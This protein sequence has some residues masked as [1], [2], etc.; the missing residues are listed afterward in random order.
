MDRA[1]A[2]ETEL[3]EHMSRLLRDGEEVLWT[4]KP[5]KKAFYVTSIVGGLFVMGFLGMFFLMPFVGFITILLAGFAGS[6]EAAVGIASGV[7]LLVALGVVGL[8]YLTTRWQYKNT[9]FG[10]TQDR[11]I[12]TSGIIGRDASTL[13]L[14]DVRDV[15]VNVGLLDKLFDT[16]TIELQVAGGQNSGCRFTRV[17]RPYDLLET[18]QDL[19]HEAR[20]RPRRTS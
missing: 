20:N 7:A 16:G 9:E 8:V 12:K 17:D 15:D 2:S 18:L 1:S 11:A 14:A 3:S 19:L 13:S 4:S 10:I 6:T 5:Q